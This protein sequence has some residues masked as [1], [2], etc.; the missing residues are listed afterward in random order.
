M[1]I[2]IWLYRLGG[3]GAERVMADLAASFAQKGHQVT[4]LTHTD[5]NPYGQQ[6]TS[7]AKLVNLGK[8]LA[9][10]LR[11]RTIFCLP[12]LV[13]FLKAEKPDVI[14]TTGATHSVL[15]ILLSRI[16]KFSGKIVIRETNTISVQAGKKINLMDQVGF[17][18]A[19][20]IY[21]LADYVIAPSL[22][23]KSDLEKSIPKLKN[24][25]QVI[26]N[27]VNAEIIQQK[28]KVP[29]SSENKN[30][31]LSAGRL[32][33][34]KGYDLLIKAWAPI[35]QDK[36]VELIIL[37]EGPEKDKL[38]DL[39]NDLDVSKGLNLPGFDPNPFRY[40]A[41]A[42]AFVLSSYYEGL[43]NVLLQAMACGCPVIATNCPSGPQEILQDGK[44]GALVPVGDVEAI[45]RA[46]IKYLKEPPAP[47]WDKIR[48]I[49]DP[50]KISEQYLEIFAS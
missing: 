44:F 1:N 5:D 28:A 24:K 29:L 11:P 42:K 41:R 14:F 15:L 36:K 35:Y 43:P 20:L 31:I 37:G 47:H 8:S 27:P 22:G 49:Y 26:Y 38:L 21:P 50:E 10:F 4:I 23:V 45:R 25:V 30:F 2:T 18:F 6:L 32:V 39:A 40:M 48:H 12:K 46:I 34:Q 19:R 33:P 16:F 9:P 3:G 13:R 17:F 7:Q